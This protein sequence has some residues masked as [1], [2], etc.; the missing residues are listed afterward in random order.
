MCGFIHGCLSTY[1]GFYSLYYT[2]DGWEEG[3]TALDN[4]DCFWNPKDIHYKI[5]LNSAGYLIFDFILYFFLVGATGTLAN[6]TY[7]HHILAT[8]GFFTCCY[9]KEFGVVFSCISLVLELSTIFL[10]IRWFTFEFKIE[11]KIVPLVNSSLLTISYIIVRIIYQTYI[12]FTIAYPW[13][14]KMITERNP[15]GG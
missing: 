6:Q 8:L 3:K 13:S 2:C 14:Y 4:I 12:S 11:S 15:R 5:M 7:A 9:I 1:L 10:N